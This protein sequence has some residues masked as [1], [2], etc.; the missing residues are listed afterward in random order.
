MKER[1]MKNRMYL[2][3]LTISSLL[4]ISC[5][6]STKINRPDNKTEYL[7]ECGAGTGWNVCYK[8]ANSIC[9]NG[10]DDISKSAGFN[11]KELY[12]LCK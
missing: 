7:I 3:F 8:E 6:D 4:I 5:A 11:R 1:N 10:Y 12:I 9:K 2:L